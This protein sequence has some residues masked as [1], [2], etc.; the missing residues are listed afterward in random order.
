MTFSIRAEENDADRGF[1][2]GLNPRLTE[3][4]EAPAHSKREVELFQDGF[5]ATAWN[6]DIGE[7]ATFIAIQECGERIGYV[8][9][10]E[11]MDEIA[12]KKC[13]YIA[14]LAVKPEAEG[15][16]VA[17]SLV[18]EAEQWAKKMGYARLALDVF[19]SNDRGLR[20][21][22][23]AGFRHETVRVIKQI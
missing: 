16:G 14:L 20:F 1:I 5:T 9:V 17:R 8:N 7:N 12:G 4:I 15:Q 23:K 3:V 22:E 19:A 13:G 2:E 21:Y 10:R 11:G 6:S 18:N